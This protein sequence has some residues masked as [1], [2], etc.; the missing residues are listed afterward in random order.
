[1]ANSPTSCLALSEICSQAASMPLLC[2]S[3][4]NLFM[5]G[6]SSGG[7]LLALKVCTGVV[8]KQLKRL[9]DK[10]GV[11]MVLPPLNR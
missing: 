3:A 7:A 6:G 9:E 2:V 5:A 10:D 4:S 8:C 1:L 11:R